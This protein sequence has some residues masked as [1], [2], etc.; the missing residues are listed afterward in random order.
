M[1]RADIYTPNYKKEERYSD[2]LLSFNMNPQSGNLGRV[3]NEQSIKQALTSLILTNKGERFYDPSIGSTVK[4]SLFEP[5][6]V[7]TA[8]AIRESI[9]DAIKYHEPRV[10][11]I[12][13]EIEDDPDN[14]RY[15]VNVFFNLINI[16]DVLQLDLILKRVR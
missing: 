3:V 9:A 6:D 12:G 2:L 15:K 13:V 1:A 11:L 10:N 4:A 14:D 5:A 8:D 16:P 7:M